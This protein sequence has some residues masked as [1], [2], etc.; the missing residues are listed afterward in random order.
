MYGLSDLVAGAGISA[1]L[2]YPNGYLTNMGVI[3]NQYQFFF[4]G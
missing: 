4:L 2:D 3:N 1:G